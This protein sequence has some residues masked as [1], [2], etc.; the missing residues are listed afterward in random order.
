MILSREKSRPFS[1]GYVWR[2]SA[3]QSFEQRVEATFLSWR[4]LEIQK[5]GK[6]ETNFFSTIRRGTVSLCFLRRQE[7][8]RKSDY[9]GVIC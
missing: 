9:G 2:T 7:P 1:G 8:C 3:W 5:V 6:I 4:I